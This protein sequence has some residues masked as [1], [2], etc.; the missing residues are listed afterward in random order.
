MHCF[1][2]VINSHVIFCCTYSYTSTIMMIFE[3]KKIFLK[4][5]RHVPQPITYVL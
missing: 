2:D 1:L 5:L 3:R 4:P